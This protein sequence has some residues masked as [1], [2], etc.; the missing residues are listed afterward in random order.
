MAT[1]IQCPDCETRLRLAKPPAA[2]QKVRCPQCGLAF[3]PELPAEEPQELPEREAPRPHLPRPGRDE[4]DGRRPARKPAANRRPRDEDDDDDD[5]DRPRRRKKKQAAGG[6]AGLVIGLVA[7]IGA[8]FLLGVGGLVW[9]FVGRDK[10]KEVAEAPPPAV[11][12]AAPAV[13]PQPVNTPAGQPAVPTPTPAFTPTPA[14]APRGELSAELTE[15]VRRATAY[16]RVDAGSQ[17]ATGS[18]FIVQANGDTAYLITNHHVIDVDDEPRPQARPGGPPGFPGRPGFPRPPR[19]GP[20]FGP[21]FGPPGFPGRPGTA[22]PQPAP[23]PKRK[24]TVILESG[25]PAEQS[26][27]AEVVAYDDE[28]DLAALRITGARNLP[29][30]ID[31]SIEPPVAETQPVF[32]FGFPGGKKTITIG[33]GTIAGL[34]RDAGGDLNDVHINGEINPGNSG[35]P[36]VDANG[37]LIGVAVAHVRDKQIGFAV[38]TAELHKMFKGSVLT[39][40]VLQARQQGIQLNLTGEAWRFNRKSKV[41]GRDAV[42]V[43]IP[44]GRERYTIPPDEYV[45]VVRLTDPMHK[46]TAV[47]LLYGP[48]PK[49]KVPAAGTG[50]APIPDARTV[51]LKISDQDA[52]AEFTL[53]AG[54]IPDETYAFQLAYVNAD[55][56]TIHT[57]PHEVRLT[58]PKDPK[59]VT[60]RI[61]MPAD[62]T[63]RRFVQ[64]Q[65]PKTFPGKSMHVLRTKE[66]MTAEIDAVDDPKAVIEKMAA[67]GEVTSVQGR[68]ITVTIKK[69]DL[70]LP[71]AADVAQAIDDLKDADTRKRTAAADRLGK[72]YAPLPD[73]RVEVAKALAA[74]LTEKDPFLR[75]N[76]LRALAIWAVPDTAPDLVKLLPH[77]GDRGPASAALKA[78][79]PPAEKA[80]AEYLTHNDVFTAAEACNILKQIGTAASVPELKKVLAGK[81]N[82]L[83]AQAANEAL[84][85]IQARMK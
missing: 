10:P 56:R 67:F 27:P 36:V 19:I 26:L 59:S 20:R 70:P 80:V 81:P 85:A 55:G 42:R 75:G 6:G 21:R 63:G 48:A 39:A 12:P 60:L 58:F 40:V 13:P 7:G 47:T 84:K 54:F 46:I 57:E 61:T 1:V 15:K 77:G 73:K 32:I 38:P 9:W 24:V 66:G 83:V 14:V 30:P 49:G 76:A 18:G 78:I 31:A 16:I 33:K 82:G 17:S 4:D 43:Q 37:R 50:W 71:A 64:E 34:R 52:S 22:Q 79:G 51:P 23:K 28:A 72:V 44:T 53:P 2:G 41:R 3:V 35:G 29:A 25:T 62:E 74:Q 8:V 5:Y 68:T 45:A 69:V 65:L 11:N